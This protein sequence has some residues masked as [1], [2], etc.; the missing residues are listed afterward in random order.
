MTLIDKI[1]FGLAA[2]LLVC[3]FPL[4]YGYYMFVRY[5]AMIILVIIGYVYADEGNK[6]VAITAFA[7]A[8]LFQPFFKL[9]LG[10]TL[11]NIIDVVLA[12]GLIIVPF[13]TKK[14]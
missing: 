4:P 1:G 13:I 9:P 14:D 2:A 7:L 11:W 3:L 12:A 5:A 10:R 6:P 8:I